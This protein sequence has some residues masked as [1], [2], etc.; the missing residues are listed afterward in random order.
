MVK[1]EV[2]DTPVIIAKSAYGSTRIFH[3]SEISYV[4]YDYPKFG[5]KLKH[6]DFD[7]EATCCTFSGDKHNPYAHIWEEKAEKDKKDLQTLVDKL[8]LCIGGTVHTGLKIHIT[9]R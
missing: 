6:S 5:I 1:Y 9:E 8:S 7:Y 2:I 3:P 4:Y